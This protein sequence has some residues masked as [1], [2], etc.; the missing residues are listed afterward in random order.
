MR[1]GAHCPDVTIMKSQ[2][3]F[4]RLDWAALLKRE[5]PSPLKGSV[6]LL[7]R[8]RAAAAAALS[9]NG[10]LLTSDRELVPGGSPPSHLYSPNIAT[11]SATTLI[12]DWDYVAPPALLRPPLAN[13]D[14]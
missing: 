2:P 1:L 5:L 4:G 3:F 9:R 11:S 13:A 10:R 12:H 14:H 7:V 6:D 8:T